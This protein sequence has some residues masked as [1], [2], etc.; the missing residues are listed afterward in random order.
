MTDSS[1]VATEGSRTLTVGEKVNALLDEHPEHATADWKVPYPVALL[2]GDAGGDEIV[3]PAVHPQHAERPVAGIRDLDG[4]LN[5]PLQNRVEGQFGRQ[6]QP[7]LEQHL[8]A[9]GTPSHLGRKV[10]PLVGTPRENRER[11]G[12]PSPGRRLGDRV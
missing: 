10:S 4:Q 12:A 9:V 6:G 8:V 5:D 7:R 3:D 1:F 2:L 11:F